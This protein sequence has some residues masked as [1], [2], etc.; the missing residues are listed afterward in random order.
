MSRNEPPQNRRVNLRGIIVKDGKLFCQ[1]L[2]NSHTIHTNEF[3]CTP[4]GGIDFG[5]SLHEGLVRE[6]VEETGVMPEIGNLLFVQQFM[7]G[8]RE[9]LEFFFHIKNADD[10]E[11]LDL[12]STS[13]GALEVAE[14]GFVDPAATFVLPAFLSKIDLDKAIADSTPQYIDY[15]R[16]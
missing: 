4:G 9:Q 3:W 8:E 10:Y 5:E 13:H 16:E 12:S 11:K 1:K 7:D 15:E 2:K 6:M 14:Y